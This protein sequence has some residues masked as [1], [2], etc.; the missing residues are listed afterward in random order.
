MSSQTEAHYLGDPCMQKE[1]S[2]FKEYKQNKTEVWLRKNKQARKKERYI[3]VK[4]KKFPTNAPFKTF[5]KVLFSWENSDAR[6]LT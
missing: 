6:S 5:F 2:L 1:D 4:R 3:K